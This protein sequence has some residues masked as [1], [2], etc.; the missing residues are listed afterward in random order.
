ME[1]IT[2]GVQLSSLPQFDKISLKSK[3]H[4]R[5]EP[6]LLKIKTDGWTGGQEKK[7]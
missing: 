2:G 3:V 4:P 6:F 1:I 7:N 5:D